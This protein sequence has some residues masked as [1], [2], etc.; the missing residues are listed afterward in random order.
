MRLNFLVI[1][2]FCL[3]APGP[4]LFANDQ[5]IV[6]GK[7]EN[8]EGFQKKEGLTTRAGRGGF[9]D[10]LL[11]D[12]EYDVT[13]AADLLLHFNFLPLRGE[14]SHYAIRDSNIGVNGKYAKYGA[15][16][17]VFTGA[18]GITLVPAGQTDALFS[19]GSLW[20][21]FTIEFWLYPASLTDGE[22]VFSWK[23]FRRNG[24]NLIPQVLECRVQNRSLV[25]V[26][27]NFFSPAGDEPFRFEL[28]GV[29]K[30]IPRQWRHHLL[31]FDKEAG[32]LEYLTDGVPV[33]SRYTT[34]SGR[35]SSP[36]CVPSIG[37]SE[38][39][40]LQVGPRFTGFMDELRISRE[41]VKMP[42]LH[43]YSEARGRAVSRVFDLGY[44][45][46][47]VKRINALL[48]K[49]GDSEINFYVR[50]SDAFNTF[51]RL[52]ED[53]KPFLPGISFN[54]ELKGRYLQLMVEFYPDGRNEASPRLFE[55][56]IV[57]KPD[58]APGSPADLKVVAGNGQATLSWKRVAEDDVKGYYVFYGE[59]PLNYLGEDAKEGQSPI[60][61]GNVTV[62]EVTGLKNG[63]LYFFAV[64]AYDSS[65]PPHL[66]EFHEEKSVRPSE[67]IK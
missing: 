29:E 52:K 5:V 10:L 62:F 3:I 54:E 31:R 60:N 67:V 11:A 55:I 39:S 2:M 26:F 1:L 48:D 37:E 28:A 61:A 44:T 8:W 35:E 56:D 64:A 14:T 17:G 6:L 21:D 53:W 24:R 66:S 30:L 41:C 19:P 63:K 4:F 18:G 16:A 40:V 65:T 25:W 49:P 46:T 13:P 42:L 32:I 36:A 51:D 20:S 7:A 59:A 50:N 15:A 27:D 22:I 33:G 38:Q 34:L 23:G 43:R 9:S 57:Y 45:G 47:L 12:S 58:L